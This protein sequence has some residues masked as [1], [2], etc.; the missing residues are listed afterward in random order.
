MPGSPFGAAI[1]AGDTSVFGC[2]STGEGRFRGVA[3]VP[4]RID[5]DTADLYGNVKTYGGDIFPWE[6][7]RI[8]NGVEYKIDGVAEDNN[9][10]SYQFTYIATTAATYTLNVKLIAQ[11]YPAPGEFIVDSPWF[12]VK[13]QPA[14]AAAAPACSA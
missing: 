14:P 5:I 1:V 11:L 6:L 7:T 13:I 4:E 8:E 12:N 3:G 9:D 10:G 2:I